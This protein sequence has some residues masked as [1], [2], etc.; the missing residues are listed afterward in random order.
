MRPE[1]VAGL[2]DGVA[3]GALVAL[4]VELD[5]G[6]EAVFGAVEV[7]AGAV[8]PVVGDGQERPAQRVE[9]GGRRGVGVRGGLGGGRLLVR[10]PGRRRCAARARSATVAR[11]G[12]PRSS[13]AT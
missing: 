11:A 5:A 9:V 12:A 2:H 6:G 7:V 13:R 1:W 10:V 8:D 3:H 4:D